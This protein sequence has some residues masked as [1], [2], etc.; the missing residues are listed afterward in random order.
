EASPAGVRGPRPVRRHARAGHRRADRP[1]TG[2]PRGEET[3]DAAR[4][5]GGQPLLRGLHPDPH[6][7]RAGRQAPLRRRHQLL[8]QGQQRVQGREPQGHRADPGGDGQRRDRR[9]ARRLRR[10]APAGEVGA[11]QRGQRRRRHPRAP[12]PGPARRLHDPASAGPARGRA[13]GDRRGRAA[14]PGGPLQRLAAAHA[15]RRGH[16]R[17][18][19]HAAA[20]GGGHLAGRG[21]LRPRRGAAQGRRGDDAAGPGRADERQLLP[22]RPRV[23][24]PLRAGRPPHG[25]P[26]RRR[27]RHAPRADE[28]R[29]GDR[30][31][32]GRL[33]PLH[34]RRA[35]RQRGLRP[36][37]RA[38]PAARR[39]APV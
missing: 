28:P 36:H 5:H 17:G 33:R 2:R 23:Q 21:R 31:R 14:Q 34:D 20:G 32:G 1:G 39:L 7:L 3:A 24:P 15:G 29:D 6:L 9:P 8:G 26:R 19:A 18:P 12:H 4:P 30:R 35:G 38:L 11:R 37:G 22:E 13:G 25:H 16:R 27:D 10:P